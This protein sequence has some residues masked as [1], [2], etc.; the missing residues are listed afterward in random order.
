MTRFYLNRAALAAP[1]GRGASA[2]ADLILNETRAAEVTGL[3]KRT[4]QRFRQEG[5]G[6]KYCRLAP[7]R[8][9]YPSRALQDWIASRTFSS[10]SEESALAARE[11]AQ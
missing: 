10:T 11:V 5:G 8:V 7:G 1:D 4:L 2:A 6:P 9:G 3:S